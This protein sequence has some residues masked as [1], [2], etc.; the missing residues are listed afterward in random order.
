MIETDF[1]V[2]GSGV[3]G[4]SYALKVAQF[5]RVTIITKKKIYKTNTALAQGGVACV[6]SKTDTFEEHVADT[7]ASGDGLCAEDVVR[8]VVEKGPE[9]IRE[10]VDLGA[11]FN[12]EGK[13]K[14]DFSLGREGGH[15]Q[16]RIV[17][18]RDLT[19]REIEDVLVSNVE[20]HKNITILENH[21]AVN[22]ITYSTSMRSGLVRTQH[23][24]ICCG[25]YVLD[26]DTGKVQTVASKV[27]LLAT[28][29]GSKVYLY[30]SNPDIATGDGIAMAYRAGATVA[31]MEFVQFHPTCLFHPEAKN[32][33]ISE[34]VRGE[35]AYLIDEKGDRFMGKYS[36]DLELACRDVVARAIDNELKKTGADSVFLDITHKDADF[37]RKRFPNIYA[38]CLE[39]GIDITKEPIPV[40]PAAHYMCG[41][42]A[43]DLNGRS[44]IQCLY[45]VGETACTGLHGANRLASNSLLEALVYAH[46][47]AQSSLKEFEQVAKKP[48]VELA[49]WD[50]TDTLD[51]DEA[52]MVTH[53]WDEIRRM[54]WNYVGIVRSDKRLHR[55]LRRIEMIQHEIEEYYW[56]FKITADLIELRNLATVAELIIKSALMRKE[57]RGLHYNL[58]YPEKDDA[59]CLT[60]T[61]I[62]KTF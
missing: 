28:G 39:Y 13:G 17:H 31:N 23:E 61:L 57:S 32:F 27:T 49:P 21:V 62:R 6:I 5:G 59:N 54:M 25:A 4:L 33:L 20:N 36:P 35:G 30:T 53:N 44:D 38:K 50:E 3:A 34:A 55:A 7:L 29:G 51:G 12:L 58:W 1:L 60:S 52:I 45:A 26:N 22:L 16:N 19:G 37:I 47:A 46:N 24:N 2:I 43:T 56:D 14:Y 15:S 18:A 41:G 8:M 40:V 9:R 10:L 11:R 48:T 42:V